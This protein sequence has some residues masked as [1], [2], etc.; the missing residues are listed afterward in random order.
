[1]PIQYRHMLHGP[2]LKVDLQTGAIGEGVLTFVITLAVLIIVIRGPRSPIIKNA[3]LAT[4][5]VSLIVAGSGY[6]GP[7]MNP[8][9]FV[10]ATQPINSL[11]FVFDGI[12]SSSQAFA[13]TTFSNSL[14]EYEEAK[15]KGLDNY[16]RD[17]EDTIDRLIVEDLRKARRVLAF[18]FTAEWSDFNNGRA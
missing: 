4:S 14:K 7:S 11:A 18:H 5:T 15:A 1:M 8:T 12:V 3:L 2:S 17:L 13:R 16:D 10:A 9:N 6:T